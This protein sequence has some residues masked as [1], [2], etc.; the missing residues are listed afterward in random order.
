MIVL[1]LRLFAWYVIF[2][3]EI[4]FISGFT[5]TCKTLIASCIHHPN[6]VNN[7]EALALDIENQGRFVTVAWKDVKVGM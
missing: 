3:I 2:F 6:K 4:V 5:L 7:T 1:C